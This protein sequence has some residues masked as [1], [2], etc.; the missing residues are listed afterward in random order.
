MAPDPFL[1]ASYGPD[2]DFIFDPGSPGSDRGVRETNANRRE[3]EPGHE[4]CI[5]A[6]HEPEH[7][8]TDDDE[9]TYRVS[10]YFVTD[11]DES[12]YRVSIYF[13]TDDDESRY[14]VSILFCHR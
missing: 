1:P 6:P 13:V 4:Q 2:S 5:L 7:A 3:G 14:R 10:I 8:D 11:D 9:S 12:R